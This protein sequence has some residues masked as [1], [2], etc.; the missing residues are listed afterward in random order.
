MSVESHEEITERIREKYFPDEETI[1]LLRNGEGKESLLALGKEVV[2]LFDKVNANKYK[3]T[4]KINLKNVHTV[5][6]KQLKNKEVIK[7]NNVKK[8]ILNKNSGSEFRKHIEEQTNIELIKEDKKWYNNIY[9]YRT[10]TPKNMIFA[11]IGYL[12]LL[13]AVVGAVG[14]DEES[15][16]TKEPVEAASESE[17]ENS[18]E[19]N[20][21]KETSE[22]KEVEKE[23]LY[24]ELDSIKYNK[25]DEVITVKAETNLPDKTDVYI[26]MELDDGDDYLDIVPSSEKIKD[27]KLK[28]TLGDFEDENEGMELI[29]NGN[30]IV[31]ASFSANSD[32]KDNEHLLEKLGDYDE[33]VDKYKIDGKVKET[34]D[35]L[36]VEGIALGE[37]EITD[38]YDADEI[39]EKELAL[40][41]DTAET[42]DYKQLDKNADKHAGK[43]VTYSGEIIQ[44]IEEDGYT[45]IRM[46]LDEYH[47]DILYIEHDDETEFVEGDNI[48]VF[49]EIYGNYEYK[50]QAGWNISVPAIFAD[51]IE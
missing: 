46:S 23:E 47:N 43:Y 39:K 34:D 50:S 22:N 13:M 48:T 41:K 15:A 25:E 24:I 2:L 32:N 9:G 16:D 51:I 17:N 40:L 45:N 42:I 37:Y 6:F 27:G 18:A 30:Y 33:F 11:S 28:V 36:V 20:V 29:E 38:A 4:V 7:I 35:G 21:E 1:K 44:I 5:N 3:N 19:E 10:Q 31:N 49:G 14:E 8:L 26:G 12:I